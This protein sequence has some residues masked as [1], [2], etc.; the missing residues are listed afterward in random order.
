MKGQA[1]YLLYRLALEG[2]SLSGAARLASPYTGGLGAILTL[3]HVRPARNGAF[4]PNRILE[5][6]PD[7]LDAL[8]GR[9]AAARHRVRQPCRGA[10]APAGRPF[11]AALRMPDLR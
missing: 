3:H 11:G 10:Q 5:I 8:L 2:L 1:R 7:F 4:Q 9:L 6:T